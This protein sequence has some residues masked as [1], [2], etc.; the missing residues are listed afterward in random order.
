MTT[1]VG[2]AQAIHFEEPEKY[3]TVV[4]VDGLKKNKRQEY[5]S[6]L[7]KLGVSTHK[8][9]GVSKDENNALIRL[10]DTIAGFVRDVSDGEKGEVQKIFKEAKKSGG[11]IEI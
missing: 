7:R 1:I 5:G 4:Y 8:V 11:L 9:Q 2:I 10:A 3:T 6:Q